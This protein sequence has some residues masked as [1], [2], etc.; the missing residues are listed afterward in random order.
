MKIKFKINNL[1]KFQLLTI[2]S[3]I[4]LLVGS[5]MR[6]DDIWDNNLEIYK[7]TKGV[8]ITNEGNFMYDNAALSYYDI[9]KKEV[10]N[11]VFFNVNNV[12]LGDVAQSINVRDS[13]AYIVKSSKLQ[14]LYGVPPFITQTASKSKPPE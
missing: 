7:P 8:F 6:D 10:I 12:P 5:C 2:L 3:I 11:D 14:L 4:T 9:E 13:L 1:F